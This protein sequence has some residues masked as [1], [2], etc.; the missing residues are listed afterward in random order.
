MYMHMVHVCYMCQVHVNVFYMYIICMSLCG[1]DVSPMYMCMYMF[2]YMHMYV[3]MYV[4]LYVHVVV[5]V[6]VQTC[7]FTCVYIY[8]YMC[9]YRH[10]CCIGTF[11]NM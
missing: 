5:H 2:V 9:M 10:V 11:T 1:R 6:H 7:V 3:H 4:C 8:M